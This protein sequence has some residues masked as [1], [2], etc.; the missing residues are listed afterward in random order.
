VCANQSLTDT[1]FRN[2]ERA[3]VA[4]KPNVDATDL[5]SSAAGAIVCFCHLRW[6][7]VY[8]RPQHL[9]TRFA[10]VSAVHLWEEP[11]FE[12]VDRPELMDSI[13]RGNVRVLTPKLPHGLSEAEVIAAQRNL[14]DEYLAAERLEDFTAWYYTPMALRFSDHLTPEVTVYDCMDELSAFQGAPPE[15]IEQEQRLFERADVVF[16]GGASLFASKKTQHGNVHLFPSSIEQAHFAKAREGKQDPADQAQI[17]HPRIGFYGV[18]DERLDRDLLR[19]VAAAHPE[20]HF[21]LIGP[22]V[23][24]R[25]EDLPR[26]ANLHYL[27]QKDYA[28][29][30]AYLSGWDVAM[31]PFARNQSTRFISPTKTPEY[32]AAGKPTVSTPITD[33]VK[34]YGDMGMVRIGGTPQEFAAGIEACLAGEGEA[35]LAK[36]DRFLAGN[37]W[38]K[39]FEGM[40]KEIQRLRPQG[41]GSSAQQRQEATPE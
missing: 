39:T 13:G 26:G 1:S 9:L 5:K 7:F 8:Q 20:W 27:A 38:D 3:W 2:P 41:P 17:P 25:E 33:V 6:N 19:E 28:E 23:K 24:I 40:W 36:V 16:A 34:P 32:L 4:S 15:L 10:R 11:V 21:V 29:L 22:V 31:L 18:L 14:L 12:D 30:P 37:S 35:W